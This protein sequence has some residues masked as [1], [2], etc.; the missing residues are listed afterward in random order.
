[1]KPIVEMSCSRQAS[2]IFSGRSAFTAC[3]ALCSRCMHGPKRYLKKSIKVGFSG[4]GGSRGSS[5]IKTRAF[6]LSF[7]S[8]PAFGAGLMSPSAM[9]V[10]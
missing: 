8:A 7:I 3:R 9:L 2:T 5:P 6:G 1:M 10:N 4:I